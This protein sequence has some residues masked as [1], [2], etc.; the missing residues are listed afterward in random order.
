LI[1]DK[2]QELENIF[3]F[4]HNLVKLSTAF[5]KLSTGDIHSMCG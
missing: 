1:T 2:G 5:Y 4:I 3:Q